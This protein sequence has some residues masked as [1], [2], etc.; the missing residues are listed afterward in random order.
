[1]KGVLALGGEKKPHRLIAYVRTVAKDLKHVGPGGTRP[2][3][4]VESPPGTAG[5]TAFVCR[6]GALL[7]PTPQ[8]F[9]PSV[10]VSGITGFLISVSE[11]DPV[12]VAVQL[13]GLFACSPAAS[14]KAPVDLTFELVGKVIGPGVSQID[15]IIGVETAAA[16]LVDGRAEPAQANGGNAFIEVDSGGAM[17]ENFDECLR[18]FSPIPRV[19]VTRPG[20]LGIHLRVENQERIEGGRC[21]FRLCPDSLS[22]TM[23]SYY[24]HERNIVPR[25]TI[26][27]DQRGVDDPHDN[28]SLTI[29]ADGHVWVFIAGRRRDRPGQIFR[30]TA[31][32]SVDEFEEVAEREMT[33]SQIWNV[34]GEGFLH[35]FTKYTRGRELYWETTPNGHTWGEP[36]KLAGFLGHYQVSRLH[37]QTVG[38]AFN[39]HPEGSV[40]RR[41]NL[42]YAQTSD[43]GQTWTTADGRALGTPLANAHNPALVIDYE[44]QGRLVYVLQLVF[45][46]EGHP[47]ILYLTSGGHDPGPENGPRNWKVTR[48]TGSAWLTSTVTQSDHNYDAGSLFILEDRWTL[49]APA[50]P[51]PQPHHTGGEIGLWQSFDQGETWNLQRRVTRK[52]P[53]N[54]S[55]LRR[56]HHPVDPFFAMWADGNSARF[57]ISQL[58]FTNSTGDRVFTLPYHMPDEEAEP[59][60]V[61]FRPQSP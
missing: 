19:E 27:R 45:D 35:L 55:Y 8:L 46:E 16:D 38:T 18:R 34:P 54:H 20:R 48:W 24:D 60:P 59:I 7:D 36:Q 5:P 2:D 13:P 28:P 40:D 56:P 31:P 52:S 6:T 3:A 4:G 29:D 61:P 12:K 44:A 32:Y 15:E 9:L 1:M 49:L 41:T 37:Q 51:G 23:A 14:I 10:R 25:P 57:S 22:R 21:K 50:L 53:F 26:V 42:Y 39:Y 30:A 33:Y 47:V 58:Y 43:F 11:V 17:A